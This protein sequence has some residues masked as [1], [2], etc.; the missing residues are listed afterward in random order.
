L[1]KLRRET[2]LIKNGKTIESIVEGKVV[3]FENGEKRIIDTTSETLELRPIYIDDLKPNSKR[4]LNQ[5]R[6]TLS[7]YV[8]ERQL[9]VRS[10]TTFRR[11]MV[12]V[13]QESLDGAAELLTE[14][15]ELAKAKGYSVKVIS[16]WWLRHMLQTAALI[17][18]AAS[19]LY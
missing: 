12:K 14:Q 8:S 5:N 6:L 3:E 1:T 15:L 11:E 9:L 7:R 19:R 2:Y 18:F 17:I 10:K 16:V 13:Y 4:R